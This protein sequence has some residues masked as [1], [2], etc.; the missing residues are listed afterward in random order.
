M[1]KMVLF[2]TNKGGRSITIKSQTTK[3]KLENL[4][5]AV[6]VSFGDSSLLD[7]QGHN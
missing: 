1:E 5:L 7:K 6:K 4:N 3:K 2:R